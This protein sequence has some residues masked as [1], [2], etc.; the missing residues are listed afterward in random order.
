MCKY[1]CNAVPCG[2]C[3]YV[4]K[5]ENFAAAGTGMLVVSNYN[6]SSTRMGCYQSDCD[7]HYGFLKCMRGIGEPILL[8]E[9]DL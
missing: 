8:W 5:A 7:H 9:C 1:N 6:Y 2:E 4:K 3:D